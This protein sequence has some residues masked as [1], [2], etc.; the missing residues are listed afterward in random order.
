VGEVVSLRGSQRKK[1]LDE[2]DERNKRE[3]I[4]EDFIQEV[5]DLYPKHFKKPL[6]QGDEEEVPNVIFTARM[7]HEMGISNYLLEQCRYYGFIEEPW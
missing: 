6:G 2:I 4:L 1:M 5:I 7:I 3:R